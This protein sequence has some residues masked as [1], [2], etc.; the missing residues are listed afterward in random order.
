M[1]IPFATKAFEISGF[2]EFDLP[3]DGRLSGPR[4]SWR[5][6]DTKFPELEQTNVEVLPDCE[7]I[8]PRASR[9]ERSLTATSAVDYL[10][11]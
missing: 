3:N 5:T 6:F 11:N 2:S 1:C 10:P 9:D 4:Q 8:V 7:L